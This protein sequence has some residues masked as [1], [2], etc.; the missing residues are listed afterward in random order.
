MNAQAS[1]PDPAASSLELYPPEATRET[2]FYI[3]SKDLDL[4]EAKVQWFVNDK[5]VEGAA[6]L[7][8]ESPDIKKGDKIRA[9][10]IAAGR[11][12]VSN[13]VSVNNIQPAI[14]NARIIPS[15]PRG[16]DILQADVTGNDRDGDAVTIF[17][18]WIKNGENA[19]RGETLEGPFKRGDKISVKITPYDDENYGLPTLLTTNIYNSPPRIL[20]EGVARFENLVYTYQ[21]KAADPDGDPLG[22]ALTTAPPGMTV[23]RATGMIRWNVP[24]DFKGK[25]SFTVSIKDGHGGETSQSLSL[26]VSAR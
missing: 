15:H 14:A 23:D 20:P 6:S 2:T 16:N 18:E 22:Y 19:G 10:V 7:R 3:R 5:I 24:P 11:E 17:Y 13:Q 12:L 9:R 21:M 1:L 26:D 25:T 8:F 4:S